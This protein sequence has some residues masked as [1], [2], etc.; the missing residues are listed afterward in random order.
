MVTTHTS[1][2]ENSKEGGFL[3]WG[4]GTPYSE[5]S[6]VVVLDAFKFDC[7]DVQSLFVLC[8][9]LFMFSKV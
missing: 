4:G 9:I 1:F 7:L 8:M 2:I 3:L 6:E 5:E